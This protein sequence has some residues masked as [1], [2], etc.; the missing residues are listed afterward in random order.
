MTQ[1]TTLTL[2]SFKTNKFWAFQQ[3][4][5]APLRLKNI[6]GLKFYKFLGTGGG[7]GFSLRPDFSTYAFLGV[8]E[9]LSFY[10]NC[11]QK[12]P[13]FKTYQEKATSQRDLILNAVKSH[14][15]WSGQNP[16]K[17]KPGLEAKGNQKAVVITRAT[18]HW[19]RLFSFWKVVPA[20]SKA[21]E[22][23]QGVQYYKGIG[24]WPFIQQA[25]ISI[26][27]DF[28][29]V[30]TFAYKDRA[31][32]DIVKKTKQMNWY[33]EDLFSRFHLISDTTKSLD[34]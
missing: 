6:E 10:Q 29:A 32:A 34:S 24:E 26:W 9:D 25:T 19:N 23:A 18:L 31:H 13:I 12:H 1:V 2:F 15:K 22:T 21:I 4:G 20:A 3:M 30:N 8:W 33:K 14:G 28:E 5:V 11:L 17:T 16:F 27:D 7:Q